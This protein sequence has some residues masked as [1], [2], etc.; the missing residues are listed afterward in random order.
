[1]EE[2]IEV[3]NDKKVWSL[4][5]NDLLF[6]LAGK[7]RKWEDWQLPPFQERRAAIL[8]ELKK[9]IKTSREQKIQSACKLGIILARHFKLLENEPL[10][11]QELYLQVLTM[12]LVRVKNSRRFSDLI[13]NPFLFDNHFFWR[14]IA[15]HNLSL[16]YK[17]RDYNLNWEQWLNCGLSEFESKRNLNDKDREV[18]WAELNK[19]LDSLMAMY[20]GHPLQPSLRKDCISIKKK[21]KEIFAGELVLSE[22]EWDRQLFPLYYQSR[23][24][25]NRKGRIAGTV[26]LHWFEKPVLI[27]KLIAE[28]AEIKNQNFVIKLWEREFKNIFLGN[29][30]GNCL[31]IGKKQFYPAAAL[32]GV[33]GQKWPAGILDYL[34]DKGIQVV[35]IREIE[36][37]NDLSA[38][39]CYLFVFLNK[40]KPVLMV[41]SIDFHPY[42]QL[43]RK[44]SL[45]WKM[46]NEL[47]EFLKSYARA[48][49]IERVVLAK[50]GPILESGEKREERYEIGN[51][52]DISD[53]PVATFE[54]IEK[55]GGYWNHQPY[56]LESVGGTEAFVVM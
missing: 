11:I 14:Q 30:I 40:G 32:P 50:N 48:L 47:F 44:K 19:E 41:D 42:Y 38:G 25:L 9:E 7:P 21:K 4:L 2:Q 54:K 12:L 13:S 55:L 24:Y 36:N 18:K 22:L 39:Q 34:V 56:F 49:G 6:R 28:L 52:V 5:V 33:P 20:Q 45:N 35:E 37:D 31:T 29:C 1:M 53:L 3:E 26:Q 10:E 8:K 51:G 17:F 46:R 23:D 16:E 15:I 43:N 27:K